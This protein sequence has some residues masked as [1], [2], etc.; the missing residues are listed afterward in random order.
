MF[1][2]NVVKEIKV[3][4]LAG[5]VIDQA[6]YHHGEASLCATIVAMAQHFVGAN[7]VPLLYPSGQFGTRAAG[8]K[9]SASPRYIFTYLTLLARAVFPELDDLVLNYLND[10]GQNVEPE[11]C[12]PVERARHA[13]GDA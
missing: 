12:V 9:D 6:A 13:S 11:W 1:K 5:Y 8:G 7:N 4:S 2:R 10:D 3:A